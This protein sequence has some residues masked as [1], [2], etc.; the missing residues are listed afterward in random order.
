MFRAIANRR[1]PLRLPPAVFSDSPAV[2][3]RSSVTMA[4]QTRGTTEELL[5][6]IKFPA[7]YLLETGMCLAMRP[8]Y[9]SAACAGTSPTRTCEFRLYTLPK[10]GDPR[11]IP[12][13]PTAPRDP[14][15]PAGF[16]RA[17]TLAEIADHSPRLSSKPPFLRDPADRWSL[18]PLKHPPF[19][20]R[21]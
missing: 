18:P 11:Y 14:T 6:G 8:P 19:A 15:T 13:Q 9:K 7:V 20:I 17:A 12:G 21:C 5:P 4:N 1:G 2:A 10:R 16:D 3:R